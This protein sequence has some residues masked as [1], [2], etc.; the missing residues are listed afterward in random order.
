MPP[1]NPPGP[2]AHVLL[3]PGDEPSDE[4]T[5]TPGAGGKATAAPSHRLYCWLGA[6]GGAGT[7]SGDNGD[8]RPSAMTPFKSQVSTSIGLGETL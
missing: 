4:P 1:P 8:P 7:S 5:T 6:A 3:T 2:T